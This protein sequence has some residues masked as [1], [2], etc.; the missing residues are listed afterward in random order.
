MKRSALATAAARNTLSVPSTFIARI[1]SLG[2]FPVIRNARWT[3][4]SAPAK[5]SSSAVGSRTSP[6]RYSILVQPCSL[7]SNGRRA[8]PTI[9]SIRGAAWSN[10][11]RPN[12]NVP[13]GPVT[14]TVRLDFFTGAGKQYPIWR[15]SLRRGTMRRG[16][17]SRPLRTDSARYCARVPRERRGRAEGP[18]GGERTRPRRLPQPEHA[19]LGAGHAVRRHRGKLQGGEGCPRVLLLAGTGDARVPLRAGANRTSRRG[20]C[21]C[22]PPADPRIRRWDPVHRIAGERV[23]ARRGQD[24][25]G[26]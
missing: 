15:R 21:G 26:A 13:V 16:L 12:P 9:F 7:G 3:T 11:I 19:G 20:S 6:R 22:A 10:G 1:V 2:A 17:G 24:P 4:T 25:A 18:R 14:A 5:D 8:I 23:R